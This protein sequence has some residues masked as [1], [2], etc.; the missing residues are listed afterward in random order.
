MPG[1]DTDLVHRDAHA[2]RASTVL[3]WA[4]TL[5]TIP[6]A[7]TLILLAYGKVM[8]SAACTNTCGVPSEGLFT[9]LLYTPPLV[10]AAALT[11]HRSPPP[12]P[13]ACSS[14]WRCMAG[15]GP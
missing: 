3:N 4:A 15:A 5:A 14:P 1:A 11:A 9:A 6:G 8:S 13:K 7:A 10:S 2:T 12:D